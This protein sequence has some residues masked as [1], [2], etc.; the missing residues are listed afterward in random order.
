MATPLHHTWTYQ[1]LIHDVLGL[2]LN[3]AVVEEHLESS[4]VGATKG[5]MKVCQ[6]D[7]SDS[8]WMSHKGR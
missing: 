1:A 3:K 5:K 7:S 4:S 2:N 6:L 8:F